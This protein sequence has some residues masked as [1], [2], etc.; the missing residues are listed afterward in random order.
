VSIW[1]FDTSDGA[2]VALRALERLQVR[3]VVAID[4]AAV[5]VWR[6]GARRPHGYQVGTEAGAAALSGAFWGLL[7]GLLFLLPLAG[8]TERAESSAGLARVGLT[9]EFL[10]EVRARITAGTSAL[11]L[12]TDGAAVDRLREAFAD[13][14]AELLVGALDREQQAALRR[15][16]AAD[17][18]LVT[19]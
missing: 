18:D 9:D 19:R 2:E 15:A 5:V 16:F 10:A 8:G 6:E 14:S 4:D 1:R 3:R 17:D 7:F 12:L 11:F 13:T